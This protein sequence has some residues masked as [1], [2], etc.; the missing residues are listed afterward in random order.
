MPAVM[1]AFLLTVDSVVSGLYGIA[2]HLCYQFLA[3]FIFCPYVGVT[4][5]KEGIFSFL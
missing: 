3:S 1:K 4:T 5:S 2:L